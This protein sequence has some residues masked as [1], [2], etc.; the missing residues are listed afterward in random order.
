MGPK[1]P[2]AHDINVAH[3]GT[4][5]ASVL[6]ANQC[7]WAVTEASRGLK[8]AQKMTIFTFWLF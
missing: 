4:L 1:Q 8:G 5:C 7:V 2:E 6:D 3:P